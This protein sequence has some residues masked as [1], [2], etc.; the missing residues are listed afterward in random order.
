LGR[1]LEGRSEVDVRTDCCS[2]AYAESGGNPSSVVE[3]SLE[4]YAAEA[5]KYGSGTSKA[6]NASGRENHE[7]EAAGMSLR[8]GAYVLMFTS[9]LPRSD[10]PL[11]LPFIGEPEWLCEWVCPECE[12]LA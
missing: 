3:S 4:E 2:L 9:F 5:S 11:A 8:L 10:S 1:A 12:W 6:V 7:V